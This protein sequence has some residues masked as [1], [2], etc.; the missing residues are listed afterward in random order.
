[1]PFQLRPAWCRAGEDEECRHSTY[2]PS[3]TRIE[4]WPNH[5]DIAS[6]Q[7][8]TDQHTGIRPIVQ[9]IQAGWKNR[10]ISFTD[11]RLQSD[12]GPS[13]RNK[14]GPC[15]G[16]H[17][18]QQG[19]RP[20]HPTDHLPRLGTRPISHA[21]PMP[22]DNDEE[23]PPGGLVGVCRGDGHCYLIL[24]PSRVERLYA[25]RS[26][27]LCGMTRSRI[28]VGRLA[29][30]SAL[31]RRLCVCSA[32]HDSFPTPWVGA[33]SA[34]RQKVQPRT[35]RPPACRCRPD[36]GL[37]GRHD[38][39]YRRRALRLT[40]TRVASVPARPCPLRVRRSRSPRGSSVISRA[41]PRKTEA[42]VPPPSDRSHSGAA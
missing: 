13:A 36:G 39:H 38:L 15:R 24:R 1:M 28:L 23:R 31:D 32:S 5:G 22:R 2:T 35:G 3:L 30:R 8:N 14:A 42:V 11:L 29:S 26:P 19:P 33:G 20:G 34:R 12:A 25:G 9:K 10:K 40:L 16:E 17:S 18:P 4:P 21:R 7:H 37:P 27:A 6:V 41:A